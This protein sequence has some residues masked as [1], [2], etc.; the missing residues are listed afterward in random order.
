MQAGV[1]GGLSKG[2]GELQKFYLEM[3]KQTFPIVE[4]GSAKS[5]TVV[6]EQ[7]VELEIKDYCVGGLDK[8]CSEKQD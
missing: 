7:G 1:G 6:I 8:K 3:A 2:F 5:V 4:V